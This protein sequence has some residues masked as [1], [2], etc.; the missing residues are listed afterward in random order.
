VKNGDTLEKK[1]RE[2]FL[3]RKTVLKELMDAREKIDASEG[4]DIDAQISNLFCQDFIFHAGLQWLTEYPRYLNAILIRL[5]KIIMGSLKNSRYTNQFLEYQVRLQ[6]LADR[7]EG[8][9][10]RE[11]LTLGWMIE[12]YRVSCYAQ[13]LRTKLPVSEKKLEKAF[14]NLE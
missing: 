8:G 14:V 3:L 7:N 12:E 5:Q 4:R 2:I 10:K 1:L 6:N 11:L 9:K 13:H